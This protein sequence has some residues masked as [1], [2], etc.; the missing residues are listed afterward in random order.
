MTAPDDA[1]TVMIRNNETGVEVWCNIQVY[2]IS[3]A[4]TIVLKE[5]DKLLEKDFG[6][7]SSIK[8]RR[9]L[10]TTKTKPI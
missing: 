5:L 4:R 9:I 3:N 6:L 1:L 8:Q 7:C 10:V 2:D